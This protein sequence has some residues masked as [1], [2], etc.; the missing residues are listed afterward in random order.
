MTSDAPA[1]RFSLISLEERRDTEGLAEDVRRGLAASPKSLSCRFLYDERGSE[2]FE[3]ICELPEYYLTRAEEEILEHRAGEIVDATPPEATVVE[4]GS[5][6]STKTRHLIRA[7]LEQREDLHYVALDIS[8]SILGEAG[9]ALV[10]THPRL[11]VTA[12]AAEYEV[13]LKELDR[14]APGPRLLLWLGSTAGNLRRSEAAAF[15]ARLA[16]DMGPD[17]L[18]LVG[19]DLR[20]DRRVL[21]A[22]YDD[23]AG[24]TASFTLNLLERI[25]REL[26]GRFDLQA[27]HHRATYLEDEGRVVIELVST[28]SQQVSVESLGMVVHLEAGEAIHVED[29]HKYSQEEIRDLARSAGLTL[30]RQWQDTSGRM[31]LN[32]VG[33]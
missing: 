21:E 1:Q 24:V 2:L 17:D 28:R 30:K 12:V 33:R 20:K 10:Q 6:S 31:T 29:S 4:L 9:P 19:L 3:R 7:W 13:G 25:N 18:L 5:G 11:R 8:E 26:G 15:M 16:A 32:L 14:L 22:A 23:A 27:F